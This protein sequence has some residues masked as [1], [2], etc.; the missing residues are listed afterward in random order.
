[1][2]RIGKSLSCQLTG[3]YNARLRKPFFGYELRLLG[4]LRGKRASHVD[5]KLRHSP[6]ASKGHV[7]FKTSIKADWDTPTLSGGMDEEG[8][9]EASREGP[10]LQPRGRGC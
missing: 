4:D 5:L 1:M 9:V 2:I 10:Q 6:P 3:G 8:H 7:H